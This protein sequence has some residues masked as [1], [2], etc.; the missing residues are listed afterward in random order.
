MT[1][2]IAQVAIFA[3]VLILP[4]SALVARRVPMRIVALY[5][6]AWLAIAALLWVA[7]GF[8]T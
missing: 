7:I 5:G 8:F 6:A 2:T 4:V 3:L 1:D